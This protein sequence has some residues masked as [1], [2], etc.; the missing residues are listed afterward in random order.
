MVVFYIDHFEPRESVCLS[1]RMVREATVEEVQ[2]STV[3]VYDYYQPSLRISQVSL[4]EKMEIV[5][6]KIMIINVLLH[7]FFSP[8]SPCVALW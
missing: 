7:K 3:D 5:A 6:I 2:P 4:C 1:F 8:M